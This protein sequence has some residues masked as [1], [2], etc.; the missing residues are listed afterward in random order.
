V[1]WCR[2]PGQSFFEAARA[3]KPSDSGYSC[4]KRRSRR[5]DRI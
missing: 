2:H 3:Y 1:S 4:N 5:G